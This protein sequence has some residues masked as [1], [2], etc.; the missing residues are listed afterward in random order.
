VDD[1]GATASAFSLELSGRALFTLFA[2]AA[3]LQVLSSLTKGE[4]KLG[5][6]FWNAMFALFLGLNRKTMKALLSSSQSES[7][8]KATA[9][10]GKREDFED[11]QVRSTTFPHLSK[12]LKILDV[13]LSFV[14][15]VVALL[16]LPSP[17]SSTQNSLERDQQQSRAE[18]THS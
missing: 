2:V 9:G 18:P 17:P 1:G 14:P 6:W 3:L 10:E 15:R 12:N 7:K 5:L 11:A 4:I 8:S 16:T 13:Y